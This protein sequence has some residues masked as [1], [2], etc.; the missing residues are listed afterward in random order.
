MSP[1]RPRWFRRKIFIGIAAALL[2][3]FGAAA[4]FALTRQ[5]GDVSNPDVEF[6]AE[7]T[8]TPIVEPPLEKQR[9][10]DPLANFVWGDYGYTKDRRRY[11]P[12][13]FSVK[14]PFKKNWTRV[15]PVLLEFPPIMIG[16]RLINIDNSALATAYDKKTGKT[17]WKRKLGGLAASSPAFGE[18]KVYFT[19]LQR[20]KSL[21]AGRVVALNPKNGKIVWSRDLGSR[22]ESSPLVDS[23]RVYFGSES[24]TVYAM[25]AATGDVKWT[26]RAGGP[27]KA[28]LALSDGKLYF[29]A[30]GGRAYAIRQ[31]DGRS[32]W[33]TG[34]S[35]RTF[36][37]AGGNFY[38]TP[39]VAFG[40][41]Y[42]GNTD[43]RMY[44]FAADSGRLAWARSTGNYVY[45]SPAV[46]QIPGDKPTVWFG[47]YNGTFYAV[48]ARTG[49]T[50]WTFRSGGRILGAPT[51]VGNLVYFSDY[52]RRH[53]YALH[54]PTGRKVWQYPRGAFNPVISDGRSIFV[55]GHSAIYSFRPKGIKANAVP[56]PTTA[57][58]VAAARANAKQRKAE[59]ARKYR[60][61]AR[62][63][64][65]KAVRYC[66]QQNRP[67]RCFDRWQ[68]R[69]PNEA[70]ASKPARKRAGK[71]KR[72]R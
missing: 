63:Q 67:T 57:K 13:S 39:A 26:F 10:G 37:L 14:P 58:A 62:K 48:D 22:T 69:H 23:G 43:G 36:G 1:E 2:V 46:A 20:T 30:Y 59:K 55:T 65:T 44:S 38:S 61:F 12:A 66:K 15:A 27:V 9:K 50:R 47:S 35:G 32:V 68:K 41:V 40:R 5:P 70:R 33:T 42:M 64:R 56:K 31:S 34:T 18:G 7:P 25:S 71:A 21:R 60:A 6:R 72:K 19:V 29:G 52:G 11:L 28:G 54:A 51:V 4:V 24:G 3:L 16:R 53:T 17:L 8:E 45:S 49:G